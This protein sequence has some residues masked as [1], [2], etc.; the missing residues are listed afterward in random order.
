M[1]LMFLFIVS[2][3]VARTLS[4][5]QNNIVHVIGLLVYPNH[6]F[7][8]ATTRIS[9]YAH[10]EASNF[11]VC[12]GLPDNVPSLRFQTVLRPDRVQLVVSISFRRNTVD[13]AAVIDNALTPEKAWSRGVPVCIRDR[14]WW[15]DYFERITPVIEQMLVWYYEDVI[16]MQED[17]GGDVLQD[18]STT[19][20][21]LVEAFSCVWLDKVR[22]WFEYAEFHGEY[23]AHD[24]E[25]A[26]MKVRISQ[27]R[28]DDFEAKRARYIERC[29]ELAQLEPGECI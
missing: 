20:C 21:Q 7:P 12:F 5:L 22:V 1:Y 17:H 15:H 2:S 19:A 8:T 23:P 25:D 14:T 11:D 10:P 4:R 18:K 9:G 27:A 26:Y 13:K 28:L 16:R 6:C 3:H 24:D 29:A